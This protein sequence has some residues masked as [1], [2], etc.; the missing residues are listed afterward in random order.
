MKT[1]RKRHIEVQAVQYDGSI[2]SQLDCLEFIG[3][4]NLLSWF[5]HL[6]YLMITTVE[7]EME[8]RVGDYIVRG[9]KDELSIWPPDIFELIHEEV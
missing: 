3:E 5:T 2:N 9:I 1:Y 6:P 8:C 4:T 7:G